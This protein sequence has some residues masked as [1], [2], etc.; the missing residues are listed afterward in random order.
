MNDD[1]RVALG[2]A[3]FDLVHAFDPAQ[4]ANAP[5]L[6]SLADPA[7]P[8]GWL[9]GNSRALWPRFD[10]ARRRDREIGGA[11]HPLDRYTE[12]EISRALAP[13]EA[14]IWFGHARYDGAFLP[15]QQLAVATGLG[16][17]APTGLVIHPE[18]G[19]WFALRAIAIGPGTPIR[20]AP[21]SQPCT[22]GEPCMGALAQAAGARG[23]DAW[24]AWLAVRDAC[25]VGRAHRYVEDQVLYH[26]GRNRDRLG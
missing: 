25:P 15:L 9:I 8:L 24:R 5:G 1:A 3:G 22:C 26:Y 11:D 10:E 13:W 18:L 14:R 17:L 19:P 7:R 12:R 2:A 23:P 6:A 20:R 16:A 21:V 4:V